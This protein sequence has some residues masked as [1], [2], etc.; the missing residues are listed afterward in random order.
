M[1]ESAQKSGNVVYGKAVQLSSEATI[2]EDNDVIN[3]EAVGNEEG[4]DVAWRTE[5]GNP[6]W[7]RRR[8]NS[9]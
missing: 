7:R 2:G 3:E 1:A 6:C 5:E 8:G 4:E 9:V